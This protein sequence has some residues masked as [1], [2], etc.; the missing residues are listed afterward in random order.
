MLEEPF[1]KTWLANGAMISCGQD[2]VL[3]GWGKRRWLS[4][5]AEATEKSVFYF[6]DFFLNNECPWFEHE[7]TQVISPEELLQQLPQEA[8][9]HQRITKW[10]NP[11][12]DTFKSAFHDLQI[13]IAKGEIEKAVPYVFETSFATMHPQRLIHSLKSALQYAK[14]NSVYVYGLWDEEHGILGVTPELLFRMHESDRLETVACAGTSANGHDGVDLL[15]D[16]KLDLE[17]QLVVK[18]ITE[19]LS[20][21]GTVYVGERTLLRLPKI[22]HLATPI[23]V[24]LHHPLDFEMVVRTLHPTPALGVFPKKQGAY[25][26]EQFHQKIPRGRFGAPV[27][28]VHHGQACCYV[29]I[30]NVQWD[31]QGLQIGAGCGVVLGSKLDQEWAEIN[32]KLTSIK[33]ML[34]L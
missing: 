10:N 29:A 33:E 34:T 19:S 24:N 23:H 7:Q 18:G 31:K 8:S 14:G 9:N 16:P 26:L 6:P 27:G 13:K 5:H 11:N 25:W 12:T 21:L 4:S 32:L 3:V 1:I 20:S 22:I 30:R 2:K 28:Y 15:N 17:H